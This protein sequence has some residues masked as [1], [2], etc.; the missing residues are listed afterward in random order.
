MGTEKFLCI[1]QIDMLLLLDKLILCVRGGEGGFLDVNNLCFS[2]YQSNPVIVRNPRSP[3]VS[4]LAH[5]CV[6][7]KLFDFRRKLLFDYV[8]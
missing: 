2:L 5:A 1:C 4:V 3:Q 6:S 8:V 7:S